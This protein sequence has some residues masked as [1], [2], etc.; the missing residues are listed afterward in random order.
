MAID[1]QTF[2]NTR[3]VDIKLTI[4]DVTDEV[5]EVYKPTMNRVLNDL[6]NRV[7]MFDR[8]SIPYIQET[9]ER[10]DN[11]DKALEPTNGDI[12]ESILEKVS[13]TLY[14]SSFNDVNVE[15]QSIIIIVSTYIC[16]AKNSKL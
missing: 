14:G 13:T 3:T 10:V 1:F 15:Q 9:I 5:S 11:M 7:V 4:P 8:T 2:C 12:P 16:V 6:S